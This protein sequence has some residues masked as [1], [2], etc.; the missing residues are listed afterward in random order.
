MGAMGAQFSQAAGSLLIQALS[1]RLLGTSD[2]A[3]VALLLS[4]IVLAT[5][6]S[7]GLIGDS[8]TVLD[9]HDPV[10]RTALR[11]LM[12]VVVLGSAVVGA[13]SSS[14]THLVGTEDSVLFG[15]LLA[16]WMAEDV[17]RRLLMA[18]L[19]F[20][21]IV[22]VDLTHLVI[23]S[24]FV[25]SC[26]VLTGHSPSLRVFVIALS[27]G[28]I[29]ASVVALVVLP[30]KERYWG[31]AQAGGVRTVLD[32]GVSRSVQAALRPAVLQTLRVIVVVVAGR[33]AYASLEAARLYVAPALLAVNGI[34][35][36]LLSTFAV[37][38]GALRRS[39]LWR[40]D[41]AASMLMAASAL[42]TGAM[43]V[44]A[45]INPRLVSGNV[46]VSTAAVAA[47]GIYTA[48]VAVSMPYGSLAAVRGRQFPVLMIRIADSVSSIAFLCAG[49]LPALVAIDQAPTLVAAGS[50]VGTFLL[51]PL[52]ARSVIVPPRHRSP[53]SW[54]LGGSRF[55]VPTRRTW[56]S[57]E[58]GD[59]PSSRRLTGTHG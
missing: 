38:T 29:G 14:V 25:L 4:N 13:A 57:T 5:G 18:S 31:R 1:A 36:F 32:F 59:T 8:L 17:L 20:W 46:P 50:L 44:L 43:V 9:R 12:V 19:R 56:V 6:I 49:L 27:L 26:G 47:W 52:A 24:G 41:G 48:C 58:R 53:D 45:R 3:A 10:I 2:F 7:T 28:Q 55:A 39:A 21:A 22:A 11:R 35:S 15:F 33:T 37:R 16:L 30:A 51:R 40:A 34:G 23:S 54:R 42:L